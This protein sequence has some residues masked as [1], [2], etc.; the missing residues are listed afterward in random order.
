M[1]VRYV[2]V[3]VFGSIRSKTFW[4]TVSLCAEELAGPAIELPQHAG[5]ADREH[6]LVGAD[7]DEHALEH[8]VEIERFA[9][10]VLEVPRQLAVVDVQA[11]RVDA[12]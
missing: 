5:L 11:P 7:V 1:S 2:G 10:N 4:K 3:P 9:G 12:V 6:E 8:L